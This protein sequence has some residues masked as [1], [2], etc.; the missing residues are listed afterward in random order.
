VAPSKRSLPVA[1]F[2]SG[3]GG[4]TVLHE[5]LVSL[6]HEDFVYLGDTARFPY[7]DRS[8]AELLAFAR[9]LAGILLE[10][11]AKLLVVACNSATSA[12]LPGLRSELPGELPLVGVVR[13]ESGLAA[14]ATRNGRIGLIATPATVES[15]AYQ[16]TLAEA[17]PA[18]E[19]HAVATAEL[20]PLI[21]LGGDV[22]HRVLACIEGAC[23]PLKAAGVDTVILGCTHY[24]L[25]RPV[26]QRELGRGVVIVSSGEAIAD[27]VEGELRAAGL[28]ND[29]DRRGHYRFLAS[30]DPD[31]FRRLGTRFLQL[32]IDEVRHVEV[33]GAPRRR[34]A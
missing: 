4:L 5:C 7:G 3:V 11:G 1:V 21:Q 8:P 18:A 33:A 22:D 6:P 10:E 9:E 26:L 15:G 16:R 24:P 13:P 2:D 27:T 32:P 19:L 30:G 28:E 34:A 14:K 29:D 12:A 17:A 23:R 31:E 20:A 25:V